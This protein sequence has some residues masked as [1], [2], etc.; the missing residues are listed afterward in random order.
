[1]QF[2]IRHFMRGRVRLFV[3]ALCRRRQLAEATLSWLQSQQAVKRARTSYECASLVVEY[4]VAQEKLLTRLRLMDC[5]ELELFVG[6]AE[7]TEPLSDAPSTAAL[8]PPHLPRRFPMVLPTL[9]LAMAFSL[10]PIVRALNFPLMLWNAYAIALRAWRVWRREKRLNVDFLDTLAIA[11]SLLQGNPIAGA[12]VIWLIKLV[13]WIRDLT[14]A[15]SKRAISDLLELQS[16]TAWIRRDGSIVSIPARELVNGDVVI[17]YP[18]ELIPI[19]GDILEGSATIDQKTITGEGLPVSRG[20]GESVYAATVIRDGQLTFRATRVGS[21]TT[22]AQI[23]RLVD[24]AP[25]GDTRMQ[26][27]TIGR[28]TSS[29]NAWI[30]RWNRSALERFRSLSISGHCRLRYRKFELR[31]P[32]QCC[33][34]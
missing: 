21:E 16:E 32:P 7:R 8:L 10:S 2:A 6:A 24:S 27:R 17:V 28:P 25:V 26:R 34:R 18:G 19:D 3:P 15:G 12:L 22:A 31:R 9:S 5:A 23:V 29:A 33:P 14:A 30:G 11:A 20:R 4:D 1:M 13:D